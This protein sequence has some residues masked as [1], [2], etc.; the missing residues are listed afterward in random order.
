MLEVVTLVGAKVVSLTP[1][2]AVTSEDLAE[3]HAACGLPRDRLV[4]IHPGAGDP[5][6]RWPLDRFVCVAEALRD[7]GYVPV[8]VGGSADTEA[9]EALVTALRGCA[10]NLAGRLSLRGLVGLL[11][12]ARLFVGNDSGPLHIAEAVGTPTVGIYWCGNIVNADP[13]TR[14]TH[15]PVLSW[16]NTCPVCG[17]GMMD[18]R[19]EHDVSFA[20]L[21]PLP[22]V[23]DHVFDLLARPG[24]TCLS[25]APV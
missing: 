2:L 14:A 25:S 1:E 7:R 9:G 3:A 4:A 6:R 23:L 21:A 8:V 17:A 15:R 20:D 13:I 24:R 10:T 5:R 12:E 16:R 22:E 18:E 19:C 11:A